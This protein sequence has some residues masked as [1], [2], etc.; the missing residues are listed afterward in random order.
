MLAVTVPLSLK[1]NNFAWCSDCSYVFYM[2]L[3]TNSDFCLIKPQLIV[4][5]ITEVETV[6]CAVRTESLYK[7]DNVSSLG[8]SKMKKGCVAL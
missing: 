3:R 1:L 8:F 7:T 2:D 4:L 5:F 6:C